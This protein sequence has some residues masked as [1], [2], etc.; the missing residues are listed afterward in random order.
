MIR[1]NFLKALCASPLGLLFKSRPR[2]KIVGWIKPKG[3]MKKC[4]GLKYP[5]WTTDTSSNESYIW[6]VWYPDSP[7]FRA[8][9]IMS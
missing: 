9:T 2:I 1:R 6:S 7:S 5:V 3:G 4:S 8:F